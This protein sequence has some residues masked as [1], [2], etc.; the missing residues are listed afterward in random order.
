MTNEEAVAIAKKNDV[1]LEKHQMNYGHVVNCFFEKFCEEK[2][3]QPTFVFGHPIEISPLSKIDYA[4]KRFTKRFELFIGKKEY[5]N[6][7]AELNDPIDQYNRF[8]E[9]VKEKNLGNIEANE[10][11]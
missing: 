7:Y 4:D 9:Q 3:I 6:A 11:D 1:F 10:I 8:N 2:C 5:A